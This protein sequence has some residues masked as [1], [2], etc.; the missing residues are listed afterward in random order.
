M[1]GAIKVRSA[2]WTQESV[3]T[4]LGEAAGQ[5]VLQE[6]S[7]EDIGRKR[8]APGL[9]RPRVRVSEGDA[10]VLEGFQRVVAEGDAV[11]VARER[12]DGVIAGPD[13]LDVHGP[14]AAPDRGIDRRV[15]VGS[16]ESRAHLCAEDLGEHVS[17]REEARMGRLDPRGAVR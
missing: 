4:D 12:A 5:D 7:N 10:A 15:Q 2:A 16:H 3:G 14:L 1:S 11:D 6:S 8:Q 13:L 9:V 17:R